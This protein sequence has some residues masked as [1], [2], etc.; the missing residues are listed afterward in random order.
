M[1]DEMSALLY[2]WTGAPRPGEGNLARGKV[3]QGSVADKQSPQ[4]HL[5]RTSRA[6]GTDT[7]GPGPYSVVP[8]ITALLNSNRHP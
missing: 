2:P 8:S 5:P 1:N 3:Y 7:L 6:P 4:W